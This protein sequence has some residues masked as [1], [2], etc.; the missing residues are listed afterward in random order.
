MRS[1]A[2]PDQTVRV[3][4]DP[5]RPTPWSF[6]PETVRMTA[7]GRIIL[8]QHPA[9]Q[10]WSFTG[11]AVTGK[12]GTPNPPSDEFTRD[13]GHSSP[14]QLTIQDAWTTQGTYCYTV[15]ISADGGS[16]TS[17]DPQIINEAPPGP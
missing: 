12:R 5:S 7:A 6:E 16:L 13:A 17:P 8:M 4:Y 10:G 15:T 14:T 2:T 11:F 9:N 3:T 1:K